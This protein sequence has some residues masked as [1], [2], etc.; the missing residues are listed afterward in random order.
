M[1]WAFISLPVGTAFAQTNA[2]ATPP[3]MDSVLDDARK[4][5]DSVQKGIKGEVSDAELTRLRGIAQDVQA[6]A[7]DAATKLEPQVTSVTARLTELGKPAEGAPEAADVAEQ[8]KQLEKNRVALDAQVKLARLLSVEAEQ[9]ATQ[10]SAMRRA[11][12]Q[13]RLGERT[14]S[15]VSRRFWSDL[16]KDLP[17]DSMRLRAISAEIQAGVRGTSG[18]TWAGLIAAMAALMLLRKWAGSRMLKLSATRVPAGRLRRSL[19][20]LVLV[21]LSSITPVIV[22]LLIY[23]G[24]RANPALSD[25]TA[26]FLFGLCGA[27]GF[28]GY[29]AGLGSSLLS[30]D[31]SSWRLP[32]IS[33]DLAAR[34]RWFPLNM[35]IIMVLIWT[36]ERISVLANLSLS[37]T[38]AINCVLGLAE[39]L[40]LM[41][42]LARSNILK[43]HVSVDPENPAPPPPFWLSALAVIAW[44]VLIVSLV[45]LLAGY[46]ALGGFLVKQAG[47]TLVVLAS[48]YLFGVVIDDAFMTLRSATREAEDGQAP[49]LASPKARDQA[50][51]VLSGLGRMLLVMLALMLLLAPFGEGPGDLLQ[52]VDFLHNGI[53]LGAISIRPA[54]VLQALLM[55]AVGVMAI[56]LLKRWLT[57]RY[58]PTTSL[59]AGMRVSATTLFGYAGLV[60]VVSF[61][62]SAVGIGLERVA[63]VASALSVGIGFGLQAVVQNF[64]SGLILLA[65]RPVKVG[66]WV[67]LGGVEGDIRRINVR[68]TEI[69]MGDRSTVIVP[70]SEFITKTVRNVTHT[71]PIGLVSFKLPMPLETDPEVVRDLIKGAFIEHPDVLETPAPNVQLDSIDGRSIIFNASGFVASPRVAYGIKSQIL[72][73][74]LKRLRDA[75]MTL[76]AP[77]TMILTDSQERLAAASLGVPAAVPTP[78]AAAP[79]PSSPT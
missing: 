55:L 13:A 33:D 2:A 69:Q 20:A 38:V 23:A 68:A 78:M 24:L 70:N 39:V 42:A 8:R 40:I 62:L 79:A 35:A 17:F 5:I 10:I 26:A 76:S 59:D 1:L 36:V 52:R 63:W 30:P 28:G 75:G 53:A 72:F 37:T 25:P 64:V 41:Y 49:A 66:D 48:T 6:T 7:E 27:L 58:L 32:T 12:F 34:L 74:V 14:N 61:A 21:V 51:V 15:L 60:A 56:K 31:R 50:A 57:E 43:R 11:G 18:A 9:A 54:S 71:N 22:A 45:C 73:E 29:V 19:H 67:A 77:Q 46:V 65:E 44:G 16:S 4:Q 3:S 47:W